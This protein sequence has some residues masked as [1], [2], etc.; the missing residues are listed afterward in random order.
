M[1]R[2]DRVEGALRKD[3]AM[4]HPV[5]NEAGIGPACGAQRHGMFAPVE[6]R[7]SPRQSGIAVLAALAAASGL[8][9]CGGQ[10][11]DVNEPSGTFPIDIVQASWPLHQSLAQ[12]TTLTIGVRNAG[13]K[14]IPDIAMTIGSP[15]HPPGVSDTA[16]QAFGGDVTQPG[17]ASPSRPI[18]I[19]NPNPIPPGAN[20]GGPDFSP[21]AENTGPVGGTTAYT[22][23]WALGKLAPGET[24]LFAWHLTA[25]KAGTHT[26]TY[27]IEAG[28]NGKA[29]AQLRSGGPLTPCTSPLTPAAASGPTPP[30][31]CFTVA[32][33]ST[34]S[35]GKLNA[36]GNPVT[37]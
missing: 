30:R 16:A 35:P 3:Y 2:D 32:V 1:G 21:A 4:R 6:G 5:A 11:Q 19:V 13:S 34:P 26:V 23:T 8:T 14:T 37:P 27:V 7:P 31:G 10:R 20:N 15:D 36:N 29:R 22:N 18:W 33:S 25:V 9:A 24:K 28:L 12:A 17:L